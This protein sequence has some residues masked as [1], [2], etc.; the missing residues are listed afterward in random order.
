MYRC[1]INFVSCLL[2]WI[3]PLKEN[4]VTFLFPSC[5]RVTSASKAFLLSPPPQPLSDQFIVPR[6]GS[7]SL[8]HV[9]FLSGRVWRPFCS[10][11]SSLGQRRQRRRTGKGLAL[12]FMVWLL[13]CML[14]EEFSNI[15]LCFNMHES[16]VFSPAAL[17][18]LAN[19]CYLYVCRPI[20]TCRGGWPLTL[21][22]IFGTLGRLWV[23][24]TDLKC[25]WSHRAG[26]QASGW[27][28]P[29]PWPPAPSIVIPLAPARPFIPA[30]TR[31]PTPAG[32][33]GNYCRNKSESRSR[34]RRTGG[35]LVC[36]VTS[37]WHG[38]RWS[39]TELNHAVWEQSGPGSLTSVTLS[40]TSGRDTGC[41]CL[42]SVNVC[43][44][45]SRRGSQQNWGLG[46]LRR[47]FHLQKV[48]ISKALL[49]IQ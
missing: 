19:L 31:H 12:L 21:T 1:A 24:G 33:I 47:D 8:V 23:V 4:W 11:D 42:C 27:V 22:G 20:R 45:E 41:L 14:V 43:V 16:I 6:P 48:Q 18:N 9:S 17:S 15:Q 46:S 32:P 44:R 39:D 29:L 2:S 38:V 7:R 30:H 49:F 26:T 10:S 35:R 28:S 37:C 3:L 34:R 36:S 5:V 13:F 40:Q 25:L